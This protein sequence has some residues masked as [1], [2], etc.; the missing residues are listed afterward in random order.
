MDQVMESD[1]VFAPPQ[2]VSVTSTGTVRPAL[3]VASRGVTRIPSSSVQ[4]MNGWITLQAVA[5]QMNIVPLMTLSTRMI[6][7]PN[8]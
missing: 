8:A 2:V 3:I 4:E 6:G 7:Q 5:V 1:R